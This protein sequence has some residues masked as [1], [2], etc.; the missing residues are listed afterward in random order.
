MQQL[1]W[2]GE[3]HQINNILYILL[4]GTHVHKHLIQRIT[5]ISTYYHHHITDLDKVNK[6]RLCVSCL[7]SLRV[8]ISLGTWA[9]E[10]PWSGQLAC[11]VC[12]ALCTSPLPHPP[13]E[14]AKQKSFQCQ[15]LLP[16]EIWKQNFLTHSF[17]LMAKEMYNS[18]RS[19]R[20]CN[21]VEQTEGGMLNKQGFFVVFCFV[22]F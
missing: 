11:W 18:H 10:R 20:N 14:E 6:P 1:L 12:G 4:L 8:E 15:W 19:I 22:L 3:R 17:P 7:I 13:S 21:F 5:F 16:F 2:H 9:W